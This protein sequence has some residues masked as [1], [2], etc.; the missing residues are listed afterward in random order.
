MR[1]QKALPSD[2]RVAPHAGAWIE[3]SNGLVRI[4]NG[5]LSRPTRA[6]GLKPRIQNCVVEFAESRPTRARGLKRD[7][8][9]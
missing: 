8:T 6:R 5:L 1:L 9:P 4:Q 7:T 3:T 2:C